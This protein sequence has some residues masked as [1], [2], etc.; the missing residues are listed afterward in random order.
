LNTADRPSQ[1]NKKDSHK[2]VFSIVLLSTI[3][4]VGIE[5]F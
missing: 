4:T 1:S 5:C 2:A 3:G